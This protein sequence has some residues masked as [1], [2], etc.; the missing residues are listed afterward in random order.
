LRAAC[1]L[2]PI[3]PAKTEIEPPNRVHTCASAILGL[4]RG[5]GYGYET[6]SGQCS[7]SCG[8]VDRWRIR[9][10]FRR[11]FSWELVILIARYM[12]LESGCD[13]DC[14][15]PENLVQEAVIVNVRESETQD[16]RHRTVGQTG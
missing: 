12:S 14:L 8:P 16:D 15:L 6:Y 4:I 1:I 10:T 11:P 3:T 9:Q 13:I 5:F 2:A 7:S